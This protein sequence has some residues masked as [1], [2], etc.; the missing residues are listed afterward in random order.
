[1]TAAAQ[2]MQRAKEVATDDPE[3][4]SLIETAGVQLK[5]TYDFLLKEKERRKAARDQK[6]ETKKE[7]AAS[8]S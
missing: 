1:M 8:Q 4:A 7:D 6:R 5:R 2:E 3:N